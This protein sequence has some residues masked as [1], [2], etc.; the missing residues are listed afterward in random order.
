MLTLEGVEGGYGSS[1]VLFGLSMSAGAGEVVSLIGRNGM[2]KTT[3]VRAIMGLNRLTGGSI[4]C[5]PSTH[6]NR[7][8]RVDYLFDNKLVTAVPGP[9]GVIARGIQGLFFSIA[10]AG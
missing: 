4:A 7:N 10:D 2:G 1:R 9:G 8:M 5:R 3:T 6:P